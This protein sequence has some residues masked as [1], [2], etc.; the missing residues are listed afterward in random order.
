ML[1]IL[2]TCCYQIYCHTLSN[3]IL[4]IFLLGTQSP[5]AVNKL[6]RLSDSSHQV[7]NRTPH[8]GFHMPTASSLSSTSIPGSR[9][10]TMSSSSTVTGLSSVTESTPNRNQLPKMRDTN[11]LTSESSSLN[12]KPPTLHGHL[13][14]SHTRKLFSIDHESIQFVLSLIQNYMNPAEKVEVIQ[15]VVV[16]IQ[17]ILVCL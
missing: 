8:R 10:P 1:S 15:D 7:K 11:K 13:M 12:F 14:R 3:T 17:Q 16:S 5:D 2:L 4:C 6:L 9:S